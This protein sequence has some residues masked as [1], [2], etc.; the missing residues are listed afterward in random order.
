MISYCL[1]SSFKSVSARDYLQDSSS[2][3]PL[4]TLKYRGRYLKGTS[5]TL[6]S[7]CAFVSLGS[8]GGTEGTLIVPVLMAR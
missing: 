6:V 7:A 1:V 8:P 4:Q 2:A 3:V 5:R